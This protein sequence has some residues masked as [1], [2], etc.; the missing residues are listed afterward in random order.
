MADFQISI[1]RWDD[2]VEAATAARFIGARVTLLRS[3]AKNVGPGARL[4]NKAGR[5][6]TY[7]GKHPDPDY[8]GT[9]W[10]RIAEAAIAEAAAEGVKE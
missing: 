7:L 5:T 8:L 4:T 2:V 1:R 6:A 10:W 3:A 9:I